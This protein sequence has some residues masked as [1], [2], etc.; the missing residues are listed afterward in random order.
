[1]TDDP[2]AP[3]PPDDDAIVAPE[4]P[5]VPAAGATP[6]PMPPPPPI[7][8]SAPAAGAAATPGELLDDISELDIEEIELDIEELEENGSVAAP[9]SS[10]SSEP[11]PSEPVPS[12]PVPSEPAPSEPAVP[13]PAAAPAPAPAPEPEVDPIQA[14]LEGAR[15]VDHRAR[16]ET[17]L[18]EM[19]AEPD[20]ARKAILCYEVGEL[21]E[22]HLGDE[23]AAIKS[24]SKALKFDN[25]FL[26]NLWAVRR[27]FWRRQLWPNLLKLLDAELKFVQDPAHRVNLL[28]EKGEI[29]RLHQND[30]AGA[31]ACYVEAHGVDPSQLHPVLILEKLY[32]EQ[33]NLA[34]L[35]AVMRA[36]A[37]ASHHPERKTAVL[38]SMARLEEQLTDADYDRRRALLLEALACSELT[39]RVFGELER[40]ARQEERSE[41]VLDALRRREEQLLASAVVGEEAKA[42]RSD[43]AAE[44][45]TPEDEGTP[46]PEEAAEV[47]SPAQ[48]TPG[49][50]GLP[51]LLEAFAVARLQARLVEKAEQ[52]ERA[53]EILWPWRERLPDHPVLLGELCGLA[54]RLGRW[55]ELAELL[56]A[57]MGGAERSGAFEL[58]RA[59]ALSRAGRTQDAEALLQAFIDADPPHL[60]VLSVRLLNAQ[61][62][63]DAA[64][65]LPLLDRL[66]VGAD[67]LEVGDDEGAL[68]QF[69]ADVLVQKGVLLLEDP[70]GLDAAQEACRAAREVVPGHA[71]AADLLEDI[72]TRASRWTELAQ[73][74]REDLIGAEVD[75]AVYLLESLAD[76]QTVWNPD[77]DGLAVTLRQLTDQQPDS[78]SA[79]LRLADALSATGSAEEEIAVLEAIAEA[80][81]DRVELAADVLTR[82]A[83]IAERALPDSGRATELLGRALEV[84]PGQAEATA[85]MEEILRRGERFEDLAAFYRAEAERT[86][87][88]ERTRVVL[89]LLGRLLERE[90]A[91]PAEAAEVYDQLWQRDSADR[92]VMAMLSRALESAGDHQRLADVWELQA[93]ATEDLRDKSELFLLL[94]EHLQDRL[95][96]DARAE[97]AYFRARA[98][99]PQDS[100]I[101][102]ILAE[103]S[104]LRRDWA[105]LYEIYDESLRAE[106]SADLHRRILSEL[107][108]IAEGPLEDPT[109]AGEHWMELATLDPPVPTA[110]WAAARLAVGRREWGEAA[111][112]LDWLAGL[113]EKAHEVSLA[114]AL[115]VRAAVFGLVSGIPAGPRLVK[116]STMEGVG[117]AT[118]VL[119]TDLAPTEGAG[120]A[121]RLHRR[122]KDNNDNDPRNEFTL[123]LA[124]LYEQEGEVDRAAQLIADHL[125]SDLSD[126]PLLAVLQHLAHRV[127]NDALYADCCER[128]GDLVTDAERAGALYREGADRAGQTPGA[129]RML[130][131]AVSRDA[132]DR[133]A[134]E[135]MTQRLEGL[136]HHADAEVALGYHLGLVIPDEDAIQLRLQRAGLRLAHRKDIPG[137]A[138]DLHQVLSI[139][140]DHPVAQLKL[141]TLLAGDGDYVQAMELLERRADQ[142]NEEDDDYRRIQLL[143]AEVQE[144]GGKPLEDVVDTLDDLLA[145]DASDQDVLERK[146]AVLLRARQWK[147]AVE[148]LDR[149]YL[150]EPDVAEQAAGELRK[151]AIFRNLAANDDEARQAYEKARQLDPMNPEAILGLCDLYR[152]F[153][154]DT[155]LGYVLSDGVNAY[156][157]GL[158]QTDPIDPALVRFLAKLFDKGKERDSHFFALC[159]LEALGDADSEE[160]LRA[161]QYRSAIVDRQPGRLTPDIW[162]RY[163]LHP[164]AMGSAVEL[165]DLIGQASYR[166]WPRDLSEFGVGKGELIK[167]K[168]AAGVTKEI[169]NLASSL[170]IVLDELYLSQKHPDSIE[171]I[172]TSAG[173]ALIVGS[174][175][176]PRLGAGDRYRLGCLLA[177]M[178]LSTLA[179]PQMD[180]KQLEIFVA[181]AVRDGQP[182]FGAGLPAAKVEEMNKRIRK[183]LS[184]K[185]RKALTLAGANF[186]REA[187]DL[188]RW[189]RGMTRTIERV[190]LLCSGDV[191]ASVKELLAANEKLKLHSEPVRDLMMFGLSDAHIEVR[192]TLGV[193]R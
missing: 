180:K 20:K 166:I 53:W 179:L 46:D 133:V 148:A 129:V 171:A 40:I 103:M 151:A 126:L 8:G 26:P 15:E 162:S 78:L 17:Y 137:A 5:V 124:W 191:K 182:D 111:G 56:E 79:K 156:R 35:F 190:G 188:I 138:L 153:G 170:G 141:A 37:D 42:P 122:I 125:K 64:A 7:P 31:L 119:T 186:A 39:G 11:V 152:Q 62:D 51:V 45:A 145:I 174:R 12:E 147:K 54:A 132:Q 9:A 88:D 127:G 192:M 69:R 123:L 91:R 98:Y 101:L 65:L 27:V 28:M 149:R 185:E 154:D 74:Y 67:T 110:F 106:P 61:G 157:E 75:R 113:A 30:S 136:G 99:N 158:A 167:K 81:A 176:G 33:G 83:R 3:K 93:D 89:L 80:A 84:E 175:V 150:L 165:W 73:L 38:L 178:R 168:S 184:R 36:H 85:M 140:P 47:P 71:A 60:L 13:A 130:K 92:G 57:R 120:A 76:L 55:E 4:Q 59:L 90:L 118:R 117:E 189:R 72:Y 161:E 159:T 181:G 22:T 105:K 100:G 94:G 142:T 173:P 177:S 2:N 160:V 1:M 43:E 102:R 86:L 143:M 109:R 155:S 18:K 68:A 70:E 48:A 104:F 97:E 144:R 135:M 96:D 6:P 82:A 131:K 44:A 114:E 32:Q 193:A 63:G 29:L 146:H 169:F 121:D 134:L 183:V 52:P 172:G 10:A 25:L 23:P 77:P 187:V 164:A 115:T 34:E 107:A 163:L 58:E 95:Q 112:A 66:L 14:A 41:D 16:L 87:S 108:W 139:D 50:D 24:Y 49:E 19:D 21:Q 128:L 116:A